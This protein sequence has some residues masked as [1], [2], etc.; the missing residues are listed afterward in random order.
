MRTVVV[1]LLISVFL[2]CSCKEEV[3]VTPSPHP[4][5]FPEVFDAFWAKMNSNYVFWD[6]D[7]TRWDEQYQKYK[8]LFAELDINQRNDVEKSLSYFT[9][10]TK[11]LVDGHY[12]ITIGNKYLGNTPVINPTLARKQ[13]LQSYRPPYDHLPTVKTYLDND[14]QF[15]VAGGFNTNDSRFEILCGKIEGDILY[16]SF[17]S[18]YM[19]RMQSS[20]DKPGVNAVIQYFL[21]ELNSSSLRGVVIDL[22]NNH[23]GDISDLNFIVGPFVEPGTVFGYSRYKYDAGRMDLTPWLDAKINPLPGTRHVGAP[24]VVLADNFTG[25]AA[26]LMTSAIQSLPGGTFIGEMTY[27]ATG[28]LT[29][30]VL[31]NDGSFEMGEFM[32]V[33]TSSSQFRTFDN[34]FVEGIGIK[35]DIAIEFNLKDLNEGHDEALERAIGTFENRQ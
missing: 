19:L 6:S 24:V 22:R 30:E 16:L 35:P 33:Q 20:A 29:P 17:S 32:T 10:M 12:L 13:S 4:K 23:G 21:S 27:G 7:K 34:L 8:P 25:S 15:A 26:E 28:T 14:Y 31:Y 9:A 3:I 5:D 11:D 2:P 18:C 1:I